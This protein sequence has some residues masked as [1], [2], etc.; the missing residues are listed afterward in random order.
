MKI[1]LTE[2]YM[3]VYYCVLSAFI[4][5]YLQV[6]MFIYTIVMP[7]IGVYPDFLFDTH[8]AIVDV[9]AVQIGYYII[10]ATSSFF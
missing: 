4:V 8:Y 7:P 6:H 1:S 9:L 5:S 10:F 3:C 2:V